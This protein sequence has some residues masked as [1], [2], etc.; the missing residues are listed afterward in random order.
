MDLLNDRCNNNKKVIALEC[1]RAV[2]YFMAIPTHDQNCDLNS[3]GKSWIS[4]LTYV[5]KFPL[6]SF[7]VDRSV[8]K[9]ERETLN[10]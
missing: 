10:R 3:R 8:N 5:A 9:T 7:S 4:F 2:I 1:G 6:A